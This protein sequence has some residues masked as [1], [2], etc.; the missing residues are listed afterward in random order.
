VPER[1]E[2]YQ[3]ELELA[4]VSEF[5]TSVEEI[6]ALTGLDFGE[7]LRSA[8]VRRGSERAPAIDA[9][10]AALSRTKTTASG[11]PTKKRTKPPADA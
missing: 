10:A 3:D 4:R 1:A 11:S 2:A 7:G 6:E 8:D 9:T 5:L